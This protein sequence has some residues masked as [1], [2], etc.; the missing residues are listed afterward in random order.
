MYEKLAALTEK[1]PTLCAYHE[2]SASEEEYA[3]ELLRG[4]DDDTAA[5][6]FLAVRTLY[7]LDV[8]SWE[9]ETLWVTMEKDGFDLPEEARNKIQ[10]AITLIVN[11]AFYWD[12]I[13]FQRTVQAFNDIPF[14]PEALQEPAVA[15]MDWAVYEAKT[16]RGLDP[17]DPGKA[18]DFDEDVQMF[19][20]VVLKRAGFIYPPKSLR[21]S[22]SALD[23]LYAVDPTG[24]KKEVAAAWKAVDQNRLQNTEFSENALGVQLAKL[25]ACYLYTKDRAEKLAEELVGF[26]VTS[27]SSSSGIS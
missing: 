21:F 11:P 27:A 3:R 24:L 8:L 25:A 13:A 15:H 10:A 4:P 14:D 18:P 12:S 23:K 19:V 6:L 9:P 7:G 1:I 5:G 2:K 26:Q 20:A 16:I 17:D 22:E